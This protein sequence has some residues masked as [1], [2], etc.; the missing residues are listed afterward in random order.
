[1]KGKSVVIAID[2][3]TS[4]SGFAFV[5][6]KDISETVY[7]TETWGGSCSINV[8]TLTQIVLDE[9]KNFVAFGYEAR[10]YFSNND[11]EGTEKHSLYS[12]YKMHLFNPK[13]RGQPIKSVCGN[14]SATIQELITESLRYLKSVAMDKVNSI[15]SKKVY[16]SEVQWVLTIPAIWDDS[17]KQVMRR[18]ADTAGL[19]SK[20]D[21]GK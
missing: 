21:R 19:C 15:S 3:G 1:M 20:D 8:K 6:P 16:E 18:C 10:D 4:C 13:T 12:S 2:F 5:F 9:K 7:C 14:H 11:D 17:S